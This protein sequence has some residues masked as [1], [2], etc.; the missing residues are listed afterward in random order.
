MLGILA[1][2]L[3]MSSFFEN[4]VKVPCTFIKSEDCR[5]T[6]VKTKE[7][8]GYSAVQLAFGN[9]KSKNSTLALRGH[10]KKYGVPCKLCLREIKNFDKELK[11]GDLV[12]FEDV[13][14][15]GDYIKATGLS[16]GKGFQGVVK[17]HGFSGVGGQT[18]GQANRLRAPGSVGASSFPSRVFKGLRMAGRMG[19][20]QVTVRN[21]RVLKILAKEN[22]LIVKGCVPGFNN[23]VV[24]LK[25]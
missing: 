22:I 4:G 15:E 12:A 17:R 16:K 1:R 25:K 13:F 3:G 14:H 9:K 11:A 2:K 6:Q 8:D 21:L 23:G 7:R 19:G 10:F 5:V 20:G 18:H 24:V